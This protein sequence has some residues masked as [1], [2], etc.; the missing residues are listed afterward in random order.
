MQ[1]LTTGTYLGSNTRNR[2]AGN[3]ILTH[4]IYPAGFSGVWHQHDNSFFAFILK[5]GNLEKRKSKHIQSLPGTLLF[6]PAQEPH[7]NELYLSGSRNFHVEILPSW[8]E[9]H[10]LTE[11]SFYNATDIADPMVKILFARMLKEFKNQDVFSDLV[12][13]G[14]LLQALGEMKRVSKTKATMP[15]WL[16]QVI[17]YIHDTPHLYSSHTQI[18]KLVDVHPATLAK[19]FPKFFHCTLGEY[20]RQLK[21]KKSLP[22]LAQRHLALD[23][24]A[25]QGGF[26]DASHYIRIFAEVMGCSPSTY[27][28]NL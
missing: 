7:C 19:T 21:I 20:I 11:E 12:I 3:I 18:A 16:N 27:R 23:E 24:I 5:G 1:K 6:Y 26:C 9:A 2:Q 10:K 8:F 14:L 22:L 25:F 17:A 28:N 4:S 15:V 13:E